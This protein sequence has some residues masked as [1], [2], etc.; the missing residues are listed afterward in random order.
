M[1]LLIQLKQTTSVFLI[2]FGLACFGL[3]PTA[4]AVTPPPDGGYPGR[5]TAEG[6][7]ALFSLAS[8]PNNTAIGYFALANTTTSSNNTAVGFE[9]LLQQPGAGNNTAGVLC[10]LSE[11]EGNDNTAVG[12]N[13]L[14]ENTTGSFNTAVGAYAPGLTLAAGTRPSGYDALYQYAQQDTPAIEDKALQNTTD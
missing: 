1:N 7:F 9:A 8:G 2:A 11:H 4:R 12:Y 5:N 6:D 10:A 13:A 14:F 3:S